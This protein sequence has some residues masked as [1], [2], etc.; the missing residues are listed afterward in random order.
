[1][2]LSRFV[3]IFALAAIACAQAAPP[4][5]PNSSPDAKQKASAAEKERS[6]YDPAL[7]LPPLPDGKLTLIGGTVAKTD[8]IN[9]RLSLRQFGGGQMNI[10][11]DLRTKILRDGAPASAKDI[12]PGHRVYVD[13]LLNGDKIFAKT[14]R[15]ETSANQ[16]DAR[17]QVVSIDTQRGTLSLR[18]EVAPQPFQLRLSSQTKV[19][20]AGRSISPSEVQPGALVVVNFAAGGDKSVAREIHVLANPGSKFT[21][22]GRVT[23][24]DLR[25]RRFAIAHQTDG[26]TYDIAIDHISP[27]DL[28]GLKVGSEAVVSAVFDGKNYQAQTIQLSAPKQNTNQAEKK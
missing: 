7:D 10:F 11:F 1:M 22:A 6:G 13:T 18:E 25:V 2:S 14:I 12:Q 26:E 15:I 8:P 19:I 3:A 20:M 17:G 5:N 23:F 4:T 24:I 9:D 16:G 28:R 21:F 27:A